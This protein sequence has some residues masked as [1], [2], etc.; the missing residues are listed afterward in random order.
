[1]LSLGGDGAAGAAACD[2]LIIVFMGTS[3]WLARRTDT[4]T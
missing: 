1:V 3:M 2:W 4:V